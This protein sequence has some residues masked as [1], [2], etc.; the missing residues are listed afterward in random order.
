MLAFVNA[1]LIDGTGA[2]PLRN[3]TVVVNGARI[4]A[5][6]AGAAPPDGAVVVDLGGKTLLPAFSDAHV[7]F[8]GTELL[9]RPGLGG[10]DITYD[11]ALNSRNCLERGVVSVRSA[12]DFMPDIVSYRDDAASAG[13]PS[14]RIVTAGRMFVAPGGHPHD[15]VFGGNE[16]IREN[17]CVICDG[18]TDIDAEVKALA[19]SGADWIKAFLSTMN[20]MN[21]PHPVPRLPNETLRK[22]T[23][24]AHKYGKPVMLHVEDP[25]DAEEAVDLGVDSIE[26]FIGVGVTRFDISDALLGKLRNSGVFV[27]PTMSS[28]K[29]HDFPDVPV[30]PH[31]AE[32][33]KKLLDAGV[34]IGVGTDSAIPFVPLGESIHIEFELLA[35]L[36]LKPLE[37]LRMATKGNSELLRA[38]DATGT[39]ET[40]KLADI[41]VLEADPLDDI[42]NTRK[43]G[44]VMKEGRIVADRI[45]SGIV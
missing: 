3:A 30:Y 27:V 42:R 38:G 23:E 11:Y 12:G 40:G 34:K 41:V 22:I 39:I 5:V 25:K 21:Y 26:H 29:A 2:A 24:A 20:K 18:S 45:L 6:G 4:E 36:G 13:L 43:I 44:L 35:S 9:T 33:I 16:A 31:L 37:V 32:A 7:H 15:T 17:A 8:G 19:D 14:P 10:R 28:I 1:H